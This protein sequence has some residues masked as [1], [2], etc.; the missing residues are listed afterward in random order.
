MDNE[1][2]TIFNKMLCSFMQLLHHDLTE[3][4]DSALNLL[5]TSI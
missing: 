2:I 3:P 1:K 5:K 4:P